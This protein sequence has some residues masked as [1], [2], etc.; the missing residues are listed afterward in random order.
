M[1]KVHISLLAL[2]AACTITPMAMADSIGFSV[3][4]T[5]HGVTSS[6]V[7]STLHSGGIYV[8]PSG[9]LGAAT[10]SGVSITVSSQDD[11]SANFLITG[12]LTIGSITGGGGTGDYITAAS[13]YATNQEGDGT[14]TVTSA[15]CTGGLHPGTCLSGDLDT[16]AY[17]ANTSSAGHPGGF[18]G[19]FTTTYISPYITSKLDDTDIILDDGLTQVGYSTKN[20]AVTIHGPASNPTSISDTG[21]LFTAGI[22]DLQVGS[23]VPEPSSLFLLGT[24]LF[25]GAMLLFWR[26]KWVR[27]RKSLSQSV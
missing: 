16:G 26:D 24:G 3:N 27:G 20:N 13:S 8:G 2:A 6:F 5:A 21:T 4:T 10:W 9:T 23:V 22:Q 15:S 11:P 12:I 19:E 14:V 1:N 18:S 25:A 7:P 17:S